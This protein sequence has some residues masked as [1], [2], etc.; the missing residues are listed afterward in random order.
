MP[1]LGRQR[2]HS[3]Q[4][5]AIAEAYEELSASA[6]RAWVRMLACDEEELTGGVEA[7]R[8]NVLHISHTTIWTV[9]KELKRK[10]YL[11]LYK[12]QGVYHPTCV[13]LRKRLVLPKG[14]LTVKLGLVS[15]HNCVNG[16][17]HA[18]GP[19]ML[20]TDRAC[21]SEEKSKPS[22]SHKEVDTEPQQ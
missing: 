19:N 13:E 4:A 20:N 12:A 18:Y 2:G 10:G 9:L 5:I 8:A 3:E 7:L 1:H 14:P 17:K 16:P 21:V 11:R 15:A 22:S 6:F